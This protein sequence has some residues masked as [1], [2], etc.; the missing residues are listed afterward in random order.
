MPS[1]SYESIKKDGNASSGVLS[2]PD[3]AQAIR[4]LR[5][6]GMTPINI[7]ERESSSLR[8]G[9]LRKSDRPSIKRSDLANLVR[10][11]ATALEAGLPLMQALKT[12]RQQSKGPAMPVLL[13]FLIERV[14]AGMPLHQA[15]AEYGPPLR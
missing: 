15:A 10:E 1:F 14:E 12:V 9:F 2:A 6:Q 7:E 13:D 11:I 8:P 5:E 4:R 3:K